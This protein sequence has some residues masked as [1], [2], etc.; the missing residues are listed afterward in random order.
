MRN[1]DKQ[2]ASENSPEKIFRELSAKEIE[3]ILAE[4][5]AWFKQLAE[6]DKVK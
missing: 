4:H 6:Y 5:D 3:Q 1:E 2:E